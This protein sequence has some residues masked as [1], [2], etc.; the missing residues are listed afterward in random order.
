MDMEME[1][2]D[3]VAADLRAAGIDASQAASGSLGMPAPLGVSQT[4][5]APAAPTT[6]TESMPIIVQNYDYAAALGYK[7]EFLASFILIVHEHFSLI[8]VLPVI[9]CQRMPRTARSRSRSV[10]S[11][12][13]NFPSRTWTSTFGSSLFFDLIVLFRIF[14][15]RSYC[16][17]LSWTVSNCWIPSGVS[18]VRPSWPSRRPPTLPRPW[19]SPRTSYV[20]LVMLDAWHSMI[21][22]FVLDLLKSMFVSSGAFGSSSQSGRR[23]HLCFILFLVIVIVLIDFFPCIQA[24]RSCSADAVRPGIDSFGHADPDLDSHVHLGSGGSGGWCCSCCWWCVASAVRA[25]SAHHTAC[26]AT[27]CCWCS[28][29]PAPCGS[30]RC[31]CCGGSATTAASRAIDESRALACMHIYDYNHTPFHMSDVLMTLLLFQML[32]I[33]STSS[34]PG[35]G[36]AP[37]PPPAVAAPAAPAQPVLVA[38]PASEISDFW[39]SSGDQPPAKKSKV[40]QLLSEEEFAAAHPVRFS[41]RDE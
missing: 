38:R 31:P 7:S 17:F 1:M 24:G 18:S 29:T 2:D 25:A 41:F 15:T 20:V 11:A 3:D 14:L 6:T 30:G 40:V 26:T 23:L 8:F 36:D 22:S 16:G 9:F 28:T 37:A 5:T 13:R 19:K 35:T 39:G 32:G 33:G 27:C 34:A 12:F 4:Q 10:R 21:L